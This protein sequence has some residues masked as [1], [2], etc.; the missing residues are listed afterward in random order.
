VTDRPGDPVHDEEPPPLLGRW[1]NVYL[2]LA[3][4][5]ALLVV[6]FALLRRWAS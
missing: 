5:L 1:R 4:E 2:L 6:L 3:G